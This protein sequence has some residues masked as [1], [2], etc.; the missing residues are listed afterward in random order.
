LILTQYLPSSLTG[1]SSGSNG[2]PSADVLAKVNSIM[3]K[4]NTGAP[5]LNAALTADATTLS[6]LGKLLSGLTSFETMAQS[7]AGAGSTAPTGQDATQLKDKVTSLVSNYN[8]LNATLTGLNQGRLKTDGLIAGIQ[9]KLG[10]VIN[11]GSGVI[12]GS[13]FITMASIG[14]SQ[15]KDGSLVVDATKL[16]AAIKANPDGVAKLF[17]NSGKGVA[18][19]LAVQIQSITGTTGSVQKETAAINKEV[20]SLNAKKASLAKALTAEANA[21]VKMYSQQSSSANPSGS[22]SLLDYIP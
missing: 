4:Q 3:Q 13:S 11:S 17:T 16:Q 22:S 10:G 7:F 20:T 14:I 19:K 5:Q 21:L 2:T 9:S 12:S 18:D 1:S 8:A 15:Q 6:G